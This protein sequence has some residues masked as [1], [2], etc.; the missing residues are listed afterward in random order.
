MDVIRHI[1]GRMLLLFAT[2][3]VVIQLSA[4]SMGFY[5]RWTEPRFEVAGS[6]VIDSSASFVSEEGEA[7]EAFPMS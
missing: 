7:L 4:V 3:T 1:P 6:S 5:L 2:A